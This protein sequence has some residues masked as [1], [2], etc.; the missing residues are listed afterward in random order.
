ML[1]GI[2]GMMAF[3]V[4][5]VYFVG[6]LGTV[7]L[8]AITLTFP[9]V[10]V[11]GT[12]TLGLGVGAMAV[13]SRG[14]GAGDRTMIRRYSTDSLTPGRRLRGSADRA[15]AFYYRPSFYPSRCL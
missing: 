10:M 12:F 13:I 6:K 4:I 1:V 9:V 14:I 7:P 5:D 3:N 2:L 15:G 11:V 8:A